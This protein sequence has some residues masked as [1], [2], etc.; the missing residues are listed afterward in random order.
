[1]IY[2]LHPLRFT[3]RNPG[4][5]DGFDQVTAELKSGKYLTNLGVTALEFLPVS[6]FDVGSWGYNP[7]LFFAINSKYG[8]PEALARCV[9]SAHATGKGVSMD[10]VFNHYFHCPLEGL[11]PDV[12][13]D[14]VTAWGNMVNFDNPICMQ[15]FR[16]AFVYLWNTFRLDAFRFDCTL[17]IING[18]YTWPGVV[19]T[20][21]SG[22]GWNFLNYLRSAVRRAADVT[23]RLW[24]FL[25]GENDPNNWGMT[26]ASVGGVLDGQWAFNESYPI[27]DA[28]RNNDDQSQAIC[29]SLGIPIS[30]GRPFNE[31]VR[32]G[33]SQDTC[34]DQPNPWAPQLRIVRRAPFGQGFQMAKAIGTLVLLADGI[35]MI[36]MGQEGGEDNDFFFDY[37]PA[38]D[39]N[40]PTFFARLSLY[41]T[42]GDDHNRILAWF[43]D[44]MGLRNNPANGIRGDD[45]EIV[46]RGYK[47]VAF[48]RAYNRFFVILSM[49]TTDTRQTLSWLGLPPGGTYKEI[50]NSSWPVYSVVQEVNYTNGSYWATLNANSV[51]NVPPIGGIVLERL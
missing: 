44:L 46:G 38:L 47:T 20:P 36:F 23:G 14:G 7:G 6:E 9:A 5:A 49:G 10:L 13:V 42:L 27:G 19:L 4:V 11:A 50:F 8:G 2:K 33:E 41:E 25:D 28:A 18:Q 39:R 24:P 37:Y 45:Y 15:F 21:G 40:N 22:G 34:G 32:F 16:Q 35:P 48:T 31:A 26:N 51:I 30:W 1:L 29:D 3:V 17:A 12:Y 43:R